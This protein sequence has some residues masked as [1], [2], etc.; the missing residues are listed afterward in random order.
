MISLVAR[1]CLPRNCFTNESSREKKQI[2]RLIQS[3]ATT[4]ILLQ[5]CN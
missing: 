2:E 3:I 1:N 4:A 5:K